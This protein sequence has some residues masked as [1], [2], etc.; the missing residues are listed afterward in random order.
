M[1][2]IVVV[3]GKGGTGKTS[4]TAALA[5][6]AAKS[7]V[8]L[9]DAD[10]DAPGL[11]ILIPPQ[12]QE[13]IKFMGMDG[14]QVNKDSCIGCGRCEEH[15]RFDA[16]KVEN[17]KASVASTGCEGCGACV[18]VCPTEAISMVPRQQ[19]RWFK[20]KSHLGPVVY[21]R[22][23][24]GGENSGMLVTTVKRAA[25]QEAERLGLGTVIVDGPPGI[26]CP[27]IAALTGASL[28]LAVTEPTRSGL[29]DL[30]RLHQLTSGLGVP[31]AVVLNKSDVTDMAPDVR[32]ACAE[33]NV[34]ILGEI[35]FSR[36]IPKAVASSVIPIEP[37]RPHIERIWE[38][39][40][41]LIAL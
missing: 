16:I 23:F 25:K 15:C 39:I 22:L 37:M 31:M 36:E 32:V 5:M 41:R 29:H 12:E 6:M 34:P 38:E 28:A 21:A 4:V 11:W 33:M 9:C 19:G 26:A 35:P 14:A 18:M 24:P 13:E 10:V 30:R 27:A 7:G 2:E 17:G 20:G 3:S 40:D 1:R 8:A